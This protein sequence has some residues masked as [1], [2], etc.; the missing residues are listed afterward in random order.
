MRE[1]T[2]LVTKARHMTDLP[3]A[4]PLPAANPSADVPVITNPPRI[5]LALR[6][7][8]LIA[9]I[10]PFLGLAAAITMLW[11]W[12][13]YWTDFGLLL[14]MYLSTALGITVGFHRLFT[15]HAFETNCVIQF[16][17]AVLG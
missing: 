12:G 11:G 3:E 6:I 4:T 9:V 17:L 15:H 1:C 10:L 5:S 16:I 7:T 8:N 2:S 13:F 14:G